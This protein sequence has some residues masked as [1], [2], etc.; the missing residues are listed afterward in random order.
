VTAGNSCPI[1]DGA[2]LVAVCSERWAAA[3][4]FRG[5]RLVDACTVGV[6]P[7]LCGIGPV[8]AIGRLLAR[9][10]DR[11]LAEAD[12]IELTEAFAAQVLAC[13]DGLGIA[14][15]RLNLH[16]GAIALGHPWGASGAALVVRL[17]AQLAA[18]PGRWGIA[19]AAV[20]GGMGTAAIW[21]A[22]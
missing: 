1:S 21:E 16:G 8:P 6:D 4:G 10:P 7:A 15:E 13:A 22:T 2:A 17:F 12:A 20:A 5:L 11:A 9:T 14:D 19:T 18:H 3:R